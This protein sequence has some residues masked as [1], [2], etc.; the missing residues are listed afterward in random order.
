MT[1]TLR[2]SACSPEPPIP[3]QLTPRR[4]CIRAKLRASGPPNQAHH[5]H[6]YSKKRPQQLCR[7]AR[8]ES[9][10][11]LFYF[12]FYT[13]I[14]CLFLPRLVVNPSLFVAQPPLPQAQQAPFKSFDDCAQV[15]PADSRPCLGQF[16]N[17]YV[18]IGQRPEHILRAIH[19]IR[20]TGP[21]TWTLPFL[22]NLNRR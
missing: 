6:P 15:I 17:T 2:L 8:Q 18:P 22:R 13:L 21:D 12:Y 7:H 14:T 4:V 19:S 3:P 10:C 5:S 1:P 20:L 16:Q 11:C 9:F